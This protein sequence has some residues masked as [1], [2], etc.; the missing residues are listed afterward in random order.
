M[1]SAF[2]DTSSATTS[3]KERGVAL[4]LAAANAETIEPTANMAIPNMLLARVLRR[5]SIDS[6]LISGTISVKK[7]LSAS[8]ATKAPNME[9]TQNIIGLNQSFEETLL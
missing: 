4:E 5:S 3:L 6:F 2:C 1:E 7:V 8:M 9:K